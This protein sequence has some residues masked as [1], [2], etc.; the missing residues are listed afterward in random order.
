MEREA[1]FLQAVKAVSSASETD[2]ATSGAEAGGRKRMKAQIDPPSLGVAK[3]TS[4]QSA[5]KR[6]RK[7]YKGMPVMSDTE[8]VASPRKQPSTRSGKPDKSGDKVLPPKDAEDSASSKSS[9]GSADADFS[10]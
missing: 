9:H 1:Q 4:S 5:S 6:K 7:Y 10:A 8:D 2:E 3:Q